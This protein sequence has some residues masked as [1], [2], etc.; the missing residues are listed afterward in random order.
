MRRRGRRAGFTLIELLIAGAITALVLA[1]VGGILVSTLDTDQRIQEQLQREKTGYGIL[2]ILRRDLEG[3]YCY[4]LG[5]PAFKGERSS[6]GYGAADRVSFV[7]VSLS[8]PD[9]TTGRRPWFTRISY[10]LKSEGQ[11]GVLSLYRS[12]VAHE[13]GDPLAA[14]PLGQVAS[15]IKSLAFSYLDPKDKSWKDDEWSETDRVPLAVKVRLDL[16]P[17][18]S[19]QQNGSVAAEDVS[20]PNHFE[21]IVGL[22]TMLAPILPPAPVQ[23]GAAPPPPK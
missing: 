9:A 1:M 8:P 13:G 23:P 19:S 14:A 6:E 3:C 17:D 15:G 5:G 18:E 20:N 22:P 11:G 4:A 7:T 21:M 10:R 12:A 16:V 2:S